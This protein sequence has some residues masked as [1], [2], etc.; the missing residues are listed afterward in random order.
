M[1]EPGD[2][3]ARTAARLL[4]LELLEAAGVDRLPPLQPPEAPAPA[5]PAAPEETPE[6][7]AA[8]D[9]QD[10]GS[11]L[12][13]LAERVRACTACPLHARRRHAV[14]GEGDPAAR[15]MFVGE[16][17][18]AR[19]DATGRPFVGD[20]GRLLDRILSRGMGLRREEVFIAN[21]L[22][23]R[24]PGNR[25]PE[26]AEKAACAPFLEEQIR[27]VAPEILVA[28][29]RHAAWHLLDT[30]A[31]M[32][33]L[34]GRLHR[35]PEGGPPV[36]VTWHPAYLL[37]NPAAKAETWEDIQRVLAFLD[38]PRPDGRRPTPPPEAPA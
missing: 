31:P 33:R 14:P 9:S 8:P 20:A 28:L 29:G 1:P 5:A 7:A 24:P 11:A 23:C 13:A 19:E 6:R 4:Q 26:G 12:A 38:L 22:K 30:R 34:R 25:D 10:A 2:P 21:V 27:L 36:V 18:G 17:P 32:G 15:V 3:A 16:A 35:R 37:R